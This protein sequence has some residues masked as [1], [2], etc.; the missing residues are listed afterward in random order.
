[1]NR[2]LLIDLARRNLAHAKAGTVPLADDV[3]QVS[4]SR[5]QD[6][7]MWE[8]EITRIFKRVPL[9]FGFSSEV[10]KPG[11]YRATDVVDVPVIIVRGN[12]GVLRSFVNMCSH[13]GSMVVEEGGGVTQRFTCPYHAWS[14]DNRGALVGIR[15]RDV[16][17]EIDISCHGLTELPCEE[18]A[19]LIFGCLTPGMGLNLDQFLCGFGEVIENF[20][21]ANCKIV[22][23]E[24]VEGPNWKIAYD[25]YLDYYH[26]PILHRETFGPNWNNKAVY[27]S[28]GPHQRM[29]PPDERA[30]VLD[31]IPED[32]W[33]L[34]H[35]LTGVWTIFPN[36]SIGTFDV[37]V[38]M[39]MV[40]QLFPG[41][42]P[43]TS[44]TTQSFLISADSKVDEERE[45]I[46]E[47]QMEFL[48]RVVRDEDY[49]TGSRIQ[50]AIS[51]GAKEQIF[52]GRNEAGGQNFHR[53]VDD[54]IACEDE[55]TYLKLLSNAEVIFQT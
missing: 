30:L 52:F 35:L 44:I 20:N 8:S 36:I 34:E 45:V 55:T 7:E 46:I 11:S 29:S 48:L 42:T 19:G 17:G 38:P 22:G 18:R 21:F 43:E 10:N 3:Y 27:D 23:R 32:E 13:R 2:D 50:R 54:F 5:Y 47:K 26:L 16:F 4:A 33:Q 40:S 37:G 28:W 1:M 9:V 24:Q 39:Y 6:P 31:D 15:D 12:D 53:W 51:T 41:D 25:G 49:Y 14:Y